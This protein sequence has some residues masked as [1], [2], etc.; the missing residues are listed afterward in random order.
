MATQPFVQMIYGRPRIRVAFDE[1]KR[2]GITILECQ[3]FNIPITSGILNALGVTRTLATGLVVSFDIRES[4]TGVKVYGEIPL[5][6]SQAG[7][8]TRMV[9]LPAGFMPA[10]FIIVT[11]Y[12]N[13]GKV[14]PGLR[15]P[16]EVQ[17]GAQVLTAGLYTVITSINIGGKTVNRQK[18]LVIQP[19]SPHGYWVSS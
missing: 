6:D 7:D 17:K 19:I 13:T 8:A 3:I 1:R 15:S 4:R 9:D 10:K 18:N 16:D 14:Y 5:L 2:D 11:V 12:E